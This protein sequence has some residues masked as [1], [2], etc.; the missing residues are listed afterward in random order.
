VT[1]VKNAALKLAQ[2]VVLY[3]VVLIFT[4]LVSETMNVIRFDKIE[5]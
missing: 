4:M 3:F 5:M 1:Q 2:H